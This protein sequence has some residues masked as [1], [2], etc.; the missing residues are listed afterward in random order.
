MKTIVVNG[1]KMEISRDTYARIAKL[2]K[3]KKITFSKAV[4]ILLEKVI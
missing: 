4:C 2:A 1:K 3:D